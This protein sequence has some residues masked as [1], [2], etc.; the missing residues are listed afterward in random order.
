MKTAILYY[1]DGECSIKENDDIV[2]LQIFYSGKVEIKDKTPDGYEI[3]INDNQILIFSI[4][5]NQ[6]LEYLFSYKGDFKISNIIASDSNAKRVPTRARRLVDY[7]NMLYSNPEDLTINIEDLKIGQKTK[8]VSKS[9][10]N[11][12]VI[13]NLMTTNQD[14]K[15]YLESGDEYV[16]S[17]HIHKKTGVAMTGK[18]HTGNS[19]VIY[20]KNGN[21]DTLKKTEYPKNRVR[22]NTHSKISGY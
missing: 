5:P 3:M 12:P 10:V 9:N 17:F 14:G 22:I 7:V 4:T 21:T 2:G 20:V 18:N 8:S 6:P 15:F 1:G 16:G 11:T 13:S 19:E